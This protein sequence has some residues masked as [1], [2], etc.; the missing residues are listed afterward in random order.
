LPRRPHASRQVARAA[1]PSGSGTESAINVD[2]LCTRQLRLRGVS[3]SFGQADE[4]QRRAL[5]PATHRAARRDP[6]RE[7]GQVDVVFV[8]LGPTSAMYAYDALP[9]PPGLD[10]NGGG[11]EA[12]CTSRITCRAACSTWSRSS[13]ATRRSLACLLAARGAR[14]RRAGRIQ[15]G[16][17]QHH[18]PPSPGRR[19]R[20]FITLGR[21]AA[22]LPDP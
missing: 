13:R 19:P 21:A 17:D 7:R 6:R 5:P 10:P 8:G 14:L 22:A 12:P 3:F 1:R 18:P 15:H 9:I 20:R 11:R 2:T 4:P 16:A